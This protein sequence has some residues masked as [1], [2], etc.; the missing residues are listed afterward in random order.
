MHPF[1]HAALSDR[2]N[3]AVVPRH[4]IPGRLLLPS[5]IRDGL[6]EYRSDRRLLRHGHHERLVGGHVLAETLVELVLL[7]PD[8]PVRVPLDIPE[9]W[10]RK[11]LADLTKA[12]T[13]VGSECGDVHE[14]NDVR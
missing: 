4:L 3:H 2:G 6:T 8:I 5:R 9:R 11:P 7:D 12:L 1:G 13:G 14:P 10:R